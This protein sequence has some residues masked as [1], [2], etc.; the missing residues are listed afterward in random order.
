MIYAPIQRQDPEIYRPKYYVSKENVQNLMNKSA[1]TRQTSQPRVSSVQFD[2]R[3]SNGL[4]T[5]VIVPI[6]VSILAL[7]SLHNIMLCIAF[8]VYLYILKEGCKND[9]CNAAK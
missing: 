4:Y 9:T 6:F 8:I 1:K 5:P 7:C 2:V 3:K